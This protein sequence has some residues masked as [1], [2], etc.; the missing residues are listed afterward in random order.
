MSYNNEPLVSIITPVYN[1]EL[2]ISECID[3]VL[4]QTYTNFEYI[5]VNNCST[6]R[7]LEIAKKY[8]KKDKRIRIHDNDDFVDV[9]TNHNNAF[10]KISNK[11][12]YCK[13][14][15]ADDY[16]FEDCIEKMVALAEEN[17]S[18]GLIGSSLAGIAILACFLGCGIFRDITTSSFPSSV[19]SR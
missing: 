9:I 12:Q 13:V 2:Y 5:I 14:V 18:V 10:K 6:D 19:S 1:G 11:S 15:S 7:T 8:A 4:R 17:P 16:I 3:S